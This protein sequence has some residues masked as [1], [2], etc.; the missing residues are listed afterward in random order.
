MPQ[1]W[2]ICKHTEE[3]RIG[4]RNEFRIFLCCINMYKLLFKC[5]PNWP[6]HVIEFVEFYNGFLLLFSFQEKSEWKADKMV[7]A[8]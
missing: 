4:E 6:R 7:Y 2:P 5:E 8:I 1:T 3:K